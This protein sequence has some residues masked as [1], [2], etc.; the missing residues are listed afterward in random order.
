VLLGLDR[1]CAVLDRLGNPERRPFTVQIAGTNGKGSTAAMTEAILRELGY[2][3]GLYT[4]PH[5]CRF[6]ERI[7][8]DGREADGDRLAELDLAIA[9][10]ARSAGVPLTY[11]EIATAL[12]FQAFA[13]AGVEV[14]V[15]EVGLGG[16]LDATTAAAPVATAITGIALDH[17]DV[18]GDTVE[19]IAREKA[20]IARPG[21]PL[22]LGAMPPAAELA[23]AEVARNVGAP[24]LRVGTDF[25]GPPVAPALAL[26]GAHQAANAALAAAL[27][28]AAARAAGRPFEDD[29]ADAAAVAR[30]LAAVIWPGRLERVG[31]VLLDCAHNPDGARALAAALDALPPGRRALVFSVVAGKDARSMLAALGP[32]WDRVIATRSRNPRALPPET[33]AALAGP[34][35]VTA[36]DPVAALA[37]ARQAAGPGGMVV[38]AGSV[39]LVG[40]VRA[41]L[42]GEPMDPIS[43]SDPLPPMEV[44]R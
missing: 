6:T 35:T 41:A 33:L 27:A 42:L 9:A 21:V 25:R 16:R 1:I 36:A 26:A 39:F 5:L 38:V 34:S 37:A 15:L 7:R 22:L 44:K 28:R 4:S 13:D 43:T 11:F 17:T 24:V 18:L 32:R 31:D 2:R 19:E 30:G 20:G 10:A 29:G 8:I 3:T 12:A 23:I 40:E 14:A